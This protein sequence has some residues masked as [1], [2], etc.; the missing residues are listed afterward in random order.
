MLK[1]I[2]DPVM[3]EMFLSAE[4]KKLTDSVNLDQRLNFQETQIP[5]IACSLIEMY[6]VE[7]LE[8]FVL[9]FRRGGVGFYGSIY[10]LDAAVLNEWMQKYLEEKYTF[11][12]AE[13][14]KSKADGTKQ[15]EVNYEAFKERVQ[16]FIK[17]PKVYDNMPEN[18]Y[19]RFRLEYLEKRK[20]NTETN[21]D[22]QAI[23]PTE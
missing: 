1:K 21:I 6:P 20:Q 5:M 8:D 12:E 2:T 22:A 4:I 18:A 19:Q 16:D 3:L 17:K 14:A 13:H 10:R 9:C 15:D 7:T 23:T 11:I